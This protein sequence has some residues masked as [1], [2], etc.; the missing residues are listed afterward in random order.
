VA[1]VALA[2][3]PTLAPAAPAWLQAV[4][5][6]P[7]LLALPLGWLSARAIPEDGQ[8]AGSTG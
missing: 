8:R 1:F 2:A 7:A 3:L 5:S 6:Y 4:T